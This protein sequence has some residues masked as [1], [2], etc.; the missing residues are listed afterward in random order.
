[1]SVNISETLIDRLADNIVLA[2]LQTVKLLE[3]SINSS[4]I[5]ILAPLGI[6]S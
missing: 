3:I 1:M 5:T 2:V 4:G 6:Y